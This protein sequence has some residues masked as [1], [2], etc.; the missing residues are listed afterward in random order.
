VRTWPEPRR[1][2]ESRALLWIELYVVLTVKL[3]RVQ[4]R[5]EARIPGIAGYGTSTWQS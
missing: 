1:Y 3:M 5:K 4:A 2:Y